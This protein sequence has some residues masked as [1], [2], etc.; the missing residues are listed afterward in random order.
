MPPE[1]VLMSHCAHY[2]IVNVQPN[3]PCVAVSVLM[4]NID[5]IMS[6]ISR[7]AVMIEHP[8]KRIM[9][10]IRGLPTVGT[11]TSETTKL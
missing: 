10:R 7:L 8:T 2:F 1:H 4:K 5:R 6:A 9:R 11:M 3:F